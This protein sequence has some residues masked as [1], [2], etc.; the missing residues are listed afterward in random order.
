[1]T[2][3]MIRISEDLRDDLNVL[4]AVRKVKSFERLI[5]ILLEAQ[6]YN[7]EFFERIRE[8]VIE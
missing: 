6:L 3:T 1:M 2:F 5:R 7:E 4:K 8:R